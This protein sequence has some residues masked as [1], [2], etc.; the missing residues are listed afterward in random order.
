[1]KT[2]PTL[3]NVDRE[4]RLFRTRMIVACVAMILA[5]GLIVGRLVWLQVIHHAHFTTL[6]HENRLKIVPLAP[7]RGLIYSR[8]GVV[9]AENRPSFSLVVV[10]ENADD[11][12]LALRELAGIVELDEETLEQ[13]ARELDYARRFESVVLKTDLSPEEVAT[14]SVNRFRFPGFV[15]EAGLSRH[16]PLGEQ[17]AHVVGYVGRISESDLETIDPTDYRATSHIGKIGV[18]KARENLLHGSA[19][20]QRVEVNA[21]GRVLR[22][23]E[24]TP[25]VPGADL[26]LT[27]DAHLQ[28]AAIK[29][30]D[31]RKGA[32][33][34]LDPATGA[35][36]VFASEPSFDPNM[37][38]N[39]ISRTLYRQWS[40]ST[41]RPLFN[42]ALQGQYP[43][44]ST[45]KPLVALV[46][47]EHGLREPHQKTWCPGWYSLPGSSHRYRD[48]LRRGHGHVNMKFS[49]AHSCDVYYYDLAHDLGIGR[50]HDGLLRFGLGE[51][52]GIDIPG[53]A[54]GL[55][56]SAAWKRRA[57]NLPWYP[58]ETLIAGIGQGFMLA[59]PL[60]LA[61]ATGIIGMRGEVLIPHFLDQFEGGNG[62]DSVVTP[63]IYR[64]RTVQLR[65]PAFWDEAVAG[66]VE[67][68]HGE[69]G[70]ARRSGA[71]ALVRFAGKTGTAQVFGIAQNVDAKI[72]ELPE[73]LQ[74]H[75]LFVAF[76]PIEQP[77]IAIAIIVEHGGGGSSTAAPIA[78]QLLDAYFEVTPPPGVEG[79]DG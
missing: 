12:S 51:I 28:S 44:G 43:P 59:T 65:D 58:G 37:F 3:K 79:A 20:Y 56:P 64:R 8:D 27:I 40:S 52:T 47:L 46:G 55:V 50:L 61:H 4:R 78:R 13:F 15:I 76:A 25:P 63:E 10:P 71:D 57:R 62:S 36:L 60:Q 66:M 19:G 2:L 29:A 70:T 11:I 41:D 73:H 42:R 6:S 48:W 1:M 38:V 68:V 24:R 75:A 54:S 67:V 7:P 53:E 17:M 33:V 14:F 72:Q 39:G 16:Y 18:E 5:V 32:I 49:I 77:Q 23:V 35:I 74:D 45:I 30:L 26:H 31:G 34:A 9:L 22:V 69:T 21:Q